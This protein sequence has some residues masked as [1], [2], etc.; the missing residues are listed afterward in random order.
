MKRAPLYVL[1]IAL[2]LLTLIP[3]AYLLCGS[4]KTTDQFF[5]SLFL[6]TGEGF[7]GISWDK[8]TFTHFSRLTQELNF[9]RYI[10]N[11]I[12]IASL[13]SVLATLCCA[14]GGYALAKYKFAGRGVITA[15]VL[16]SL[17]LPGAL[18]IAPSYDLLFRLGLLNRFTGLILPAIAPAFGVFLFR[19]AT[20]SSLPNALLEA[21]RIDGCGEARIFF[22][23]VLPMVK[24][25]IGAFLMITFL[26]M[27]NNF[28]GPQIVMQSAE[29]LP[30]SVG[31][32]Q[33]KGTYGQDYGLIMAGTVVSVLPVLVL[34]LLLQ[35]EFIAGLTSGAVK[36]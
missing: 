33:L 4:V 26:G 17:I 2:S 32:A 12:F 22:T 10:I 35:R 23:I 15:I 34:F 29:K 9:G 8:L 36:G 21:A 11:S 30:L 18:L 7:L 27:W 1:L 3:F 19:Q 14:M 28:I 13:S 24:P 31:V 25:M 6:P 5:A 20:I 16:A